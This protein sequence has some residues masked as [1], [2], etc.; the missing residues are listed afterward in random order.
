MDGWMEAR[1]AAADWQ[2]AHS[3]TADWLEA[4]P[5]GGLF[6]LPPEVKDDAEGRKNDNKRVQIS[7][8]GLRGRTITRKQAEGSS[9]RPLAHPDALALASQSKLQSRRKPLP[10]YV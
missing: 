7:A 10:G 1:S 5:S 3:A 6:G 9:Q 4:E 2:E 8:G